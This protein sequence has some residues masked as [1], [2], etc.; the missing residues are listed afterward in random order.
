MI[1][2]ILTLVMAYY[3]FENDVNVT[4]D[5]L[6]D[7][8]SFSG[9]NGVVTILIVSKVLKKKDWTHDMKLKMATKIITV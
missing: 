5:K 9:L 2:S 1:Y 6:C 7:L 4:S 8:F 3:L